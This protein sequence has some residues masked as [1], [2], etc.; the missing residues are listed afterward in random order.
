VAD[1][2]AALQ[3][4]IDAAQASNLIAELPPA[5]TFYRIT[6][7]LLV[8]SFGGITIIGAGGQSHVTGDPTTRSRIHQATYGKHAI[9]ITNAVGTGTPTDNVFLQGFALSAPSLTVQP[10][11]ASLLWAE[12][13]IRTL[14]SS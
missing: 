3:A 10:T 11:M 13:R 8:R 14:T 1:D 4:W 2:T 5:S 7:A 6:D 9:V 12:F